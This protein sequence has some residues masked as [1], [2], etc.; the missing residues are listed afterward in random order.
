MSKLYRWFLWFCGFQE[1]D[2]I[3]AML[4]RQKARLGAWWWFFPITTIVILLGFLGFAIWAVVH[5]I[6]LKLPAGV[7]RLCL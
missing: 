4:A 2:T 3:S 6:T 1:G 5:I 7:K